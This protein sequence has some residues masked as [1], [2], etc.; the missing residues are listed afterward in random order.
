MKTG[1]KFCGI[2]KT[3][4]SGFIIHNLD[5]E[6]LKKNENV[7][8]KRN[9]AI[10]KMSYIIPTVRDG[11]EYMDGYDY[12]KVTDGYMFNTLTVGCKI[13]KG[14]PVLY[15]LIDLKISGEVGNSNLVPVNMSQFRNTLFEIEGYLFDRYG[16]TVCFANASFADMEI[17]ITCEMSEDFVNYDFL[18]Q[19]MLYCVPGT[20]KHKSVNLVNNALDCIKFSNSRLENKIYDKTAQLL[21]V[22]KVTESGQ[23]M[24]V[25]YKLVDSQKIAQVFGTNRI[26]EFSDEMICS[27][28]HKQVYK[29]LVKPVLADMKAV[30]RVLDQLIL[31][32]KQR[33]VRGYITGF[34]MSALAMCSND[35]LDKLVLDWGQ[36]EDCIRRNSSTTNSK[37]NINLAKGYIQEKQKSLSYVFKNTSRLNEF[38]DKFTIYQ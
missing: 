2:D 11:K 3:L 23:Y 10:N 17:N 15:S 18:L 8:L 27:W 26:F 30:D 33:Q 19:K 34:V 4:V 29:D 31:Q 35:R 12:L 22:K 5:L 7:I 38:I 14:H 24:R 1:N 32:E 25:E 13:S 16:L 36:L 21:R 6:K 28:I 9:Y 37:R 20:Y